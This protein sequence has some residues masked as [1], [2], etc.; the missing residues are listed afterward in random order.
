MAQFQKMGAVPKRA[1]TE[2]TPRLRWMDSTSGSCLDAE[3]HGGP[4]SGRQ[5]HKQG[6][7]HKRQEAANRGAGPHLVEGTR[8]ASLRCSEPI[9][10]MGRVCLQAWCPAALLWAS[11]VC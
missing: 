6:G 2:G 8:V 5:A 11:P 3:R 4:V 10:L 7:Q 9:P 1:L